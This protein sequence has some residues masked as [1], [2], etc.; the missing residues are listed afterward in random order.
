MRQSVFNGWRTTSEVS[1]AE[2]TVKAGR[3]TL[4]QVEIEVLLDAVTAYMDVVTAAQILRIRNNNVTVLTQE[5]EAAQ[6]RRA[7]K[8]V[9]RTDVAQAE[10]R[11]ARAASTAD[12]AKSDLKTAR[13][14]FERV[15][16]HAPEAVSMPPL[17]LKQ[18]PRTI[19]EAWRLGEQENPSLTTALYREEAARY[20]VDKVRGELLPQVNIEASYGHR[21]SLSNGL[22]QQEAASVTGRVSVPF[23]DGGE[24]RARVRQAKHVQVARLQEIQQ[25]RSETQEAVTAAWSVLMAQRAKLK[26]DI[27]QMDANRIALEGVREEQRVGQRTLLD[28]LNAEQEFLDSQIDLVN[29]RRGVV[30]AGYRL[31]AAMGQLSSERMGLTSLVYDPEEHL[32]ESRQ[33]WF[34][35]DIT[36]AD[37]RTRVARGCG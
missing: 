4:R 35:M 28:V 20:A 16:G 37:G 32:F 25:A 2:A 12:L 17:K 24:I 5:V 1:E 22:D 14:L 10:A 34:G 21:D 18:L 8:E 7:A 9:T 30:I 23:Y 11:R 36:R 27:Q 15:V 33:N 6:T 31:L 26:S 19:E 29:A 13:A 3:E